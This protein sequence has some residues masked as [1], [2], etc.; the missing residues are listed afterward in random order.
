MT[1]ATPALSGET[2][3]MTGAAPALSGVTAD[4]TGAAPALSEKTAD[5]TGELSGS[6]PVRSIGKKFRL[7]GHTVSRIR[8]AGL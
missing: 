8:P 1:G 7:C 6:R 3:D 5:M 2:A 4:T